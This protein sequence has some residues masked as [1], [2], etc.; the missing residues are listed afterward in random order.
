ML[1]AEMAQEELPKP[2][3]TDL[4]TLPGITADIAAQLKQ[5]GADTPEDVLL[6]GI[7]GLKELKGVGDKKAEMILA[8]IQ[9]RLQ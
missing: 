5:E 6:L 8:A 4:Q 2:V 9:A 3:K 1:D 7:D